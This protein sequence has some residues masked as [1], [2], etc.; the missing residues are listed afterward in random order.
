MEEGVDEDRETD[1]ATGA[2]ADDVCVGV[3][4]E[5]VQSL[6]QELLAHHDPQ[7]TGFVT[8]EEYLMWTLHNPLASALL[9][10]IFQVRL[11][12]NPNLT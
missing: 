3:S 1:E 8:Q 7:A 12:L 6:V 10:I 5:E 11:H 4:G 9:D 2:F